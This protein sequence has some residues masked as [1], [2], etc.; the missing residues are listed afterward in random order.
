MK[1]V[2]NR[3]NLIFLIDVLL[4]LLLPT[5]EKVDAPWVF[6]LVLLFAELLFLVKYIRHRKKSTVDVAFVT[7]LFLGIWELCKKMGWA[8]PVLVPAPENVFNVFVSQR[9]LI[10]QGI[11][12]SLLLLFWGVGLA[13]VLGV[14]LGLFVGWIPRLREAVTPIANVISPIPPLVY[15]PYVVAVM[16]TFKVASVFVIFSAVFWPTFQTMIGRVGSMDQRIIQSAKVMNVSTP[17]MLFRVI[18]PY[19]MP[20]IITG[21]SGSM[22][23]AFLCLTGAELL[24]ASSGLGF[25]VKKF[26]DYADYTK[27]ITGIIV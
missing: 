13:L 24:G 15:T 18:L 3:A 26:S 22:R 2:F 27:V 5:S 16:P 10:L 14:F 19:C 9:E 11:G 7:F 25:F 23:G 12:S 20:G 4:V 1:Y 17:A 6:L 21:L 8:H